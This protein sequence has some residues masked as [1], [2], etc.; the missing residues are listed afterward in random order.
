MKR[1]FKRVNVLQVIS[2]FGIIITFIFIFLNITKIATNIFWVF[3]GIHIC[4]I[5][6]FVHKWSKE[7]ITPYRRLDR[8]NEK[9][10]TRK[11]SDSLFLL[12]V[13][14]IFVV[15]FIFILKMFSS[16]D[17]G[18]YLAIVNLTIVCDLTMLYWVD[19]TINQ[20]AIIEKSK[21]K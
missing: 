5:V 4:G 17:Y 15:C 16:L 8:N 13:S 6:M 21:L 20:V 14:Y 1:M 12:L 10:I 2:L 18:D 7:G 11:T 19:K 9:N 3:V